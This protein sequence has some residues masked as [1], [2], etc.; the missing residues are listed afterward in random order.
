MSEIH[1]VVCIDSETG[2]VSIDWATTRAKF[3]DETVFDGKLH[4]WTNP[5]PEE[6]EKMD[7]LESILSHIVLDD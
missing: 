1:A 6:D 4:R 5:S 3:S 7:K 2:R